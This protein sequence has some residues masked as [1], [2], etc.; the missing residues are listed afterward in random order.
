MFFKYFQFHSFLIVVHQ[1]VHNHV[2]DFCRHR[3]GV[4]ACMMNTDEQY[5]KYH[6]PGKGNVGRRQYGIMNRATINHVDSMNI[7]ILIVVALLDSS[8]PDS[9]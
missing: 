1:V 9:D 5:V 4:H 3:M 8:G 6:D 7:Y 2:W